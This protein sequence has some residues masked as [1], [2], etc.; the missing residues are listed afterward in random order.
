MKTEIR[1]WVFV[2]RNHGERRIVVH[3]EKSAG[4]VRELILQGGAAWMEVSEAQAAPIVKAP[5]VEKAPPSL[6]LVPPPLKKSGPERRVHK[7]HEAEFRVVIISGANSF[8]NSTSNV[9]L[10]GIR[11]KK[12]LPRVFLNERCTLFISH[13]SLRE[14]VQINCRVISDQNDLMRIQ[15]VDADSG[16]I[17]RLEQW[18][19]GNG[20]GRSVA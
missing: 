9:S 19:N 15:F 2:D 14:N 3:D 16:Q 7:R 11:L 5:E 6:P 17:L 13:P 1:Q 20:L 12:A 4:L 8:R 10:G 18:L